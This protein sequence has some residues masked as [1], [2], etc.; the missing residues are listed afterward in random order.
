MN[1]RLIAIGM[2]AMLLVA[3]GN[4]TKELEAFYTKVQD[5][6]KEEKVKIESSK[7]LE[8]LE[9][10]KVKLF[11]DINQHNKL[12]EIHKTSQKLIGNVEARKRVIR[13]EKETMDI[14][15][16]TFEE[17]ITLSKDIKNEDYLREAKDVIT[18]MSTKYK[19][20]DV[21]MSA[22]DDVLN[23]ETEL[24]KYLGSDAP[25]G[26]EVN[27]KVKELN[28]ITKKFHEKVNTYSKDEE[29]VMQ[30][31]KDVVDILNEK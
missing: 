10:E 8:K 26:K 13:A 18:T 9:N 31:M 6:S 20:H 19:D 15:E 21:L 4:S 12:D 7:E 22:Y 27:K 25:I 16:A 29:V 23:K 3:C 5:A 11:D 30:E 2:S 24:F 1:K 17:A 28:E 14:A